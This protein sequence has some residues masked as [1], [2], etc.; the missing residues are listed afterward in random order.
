MRFHEIGPIEQVRNGIPASGEEL[1]LKE[2]WLAELP[3]AV[4]PVVR[5]SHVRPDD[6]SLI[7]EAIRTASRE[8]LLH[9]FFSPIRTSFPL[10]K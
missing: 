5:F 1:P 8:T 2:D 3:L 10:K 9:R 4:G 6:Q 7:T